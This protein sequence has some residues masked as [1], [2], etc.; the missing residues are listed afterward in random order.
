MNGQCQ[1]LNY[2]NEILHLVINQEDESTLYNL[3]N[4]TCTV[5]LIPLI[6]NHLTLS[7]ISKINVKNKS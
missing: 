4:F 3:R 7:L 2:F 6:K 5:P 1:K